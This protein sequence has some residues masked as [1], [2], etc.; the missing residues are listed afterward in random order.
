M[1]QQ[2]TLD[3]TADNGTD[4]DYKYRCP[5]CGVTYDLE[6]FTRVHITRSD[7]PDHL[8][9]NGFMPETKIE[10]IDDDGEVIE[11]ISRRPE[12]IDMSGLTI[13]EF[14][15]SLP[16]THKHILLIA[17]KNKDEEAYTTLADE[18]E[19]R[20]AEYE[21]ECPSYST[22]RRVVRSFYRPHKDTDNGQAGDSEKTD[23]LSTHTPKQQAIL[24]ARLASPEAPIS[25]IAKQIGCAKSYP[26]QIY[27]QSESLIA[28][29]EAKIE[30]RDNLQT[31]LRE[32]LTDDDIHMLLKKDLLANVPIDLD[33][34]VDDHNRGETS[35][36]GSPMKQHEVMSADPHSPSQ[37]HQTIDSETIESDDSSDNTTNE[38]DAIVSDKSVNGSPQTV[39]TNQSI[40]R[41]DIENLQDKIA[42]T[43]RIFDGI[44]E[45]EELV[46]LARS[47]ENHLDEILEGASHP[48]P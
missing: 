46:S 7:D 19:T 9:Y 35:D 1:S 30:Q 26:Y 2:Q 42:F 44:G 22:I 14:P 8:N 40:Q 11:M 16:E 28:D 5:Y 27:E 38:S 10:K 23:S 15:A 3:P 47:L 4:D 39:N 17:T 33:T 36:W 34:T 24:I 48:E 20:L 32:E 18:A 43:R 29:L 45:N 12:E 31:V 41:D 6:I 13:T 37:E 21:L 25:E